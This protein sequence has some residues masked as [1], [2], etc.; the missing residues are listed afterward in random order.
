MTATSSQADAAAAPSTPMAPLINAGNVT[1]IST[2]YA[3]G[4]TANVDSSKSR[5]LILA[6]T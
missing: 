1:H 3:K 2:S 6:N 5:S 4:G